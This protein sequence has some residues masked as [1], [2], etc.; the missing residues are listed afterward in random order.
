MRENTR[1]HRAIRGVRAREIPDAHQKLIDDLATGESKRA[2]EQLDPLVLAPGMM[3]VEPA[4]K[5]ATGVPQLQ[6]RPR[7]GDGGIDL[8]SVS[9]D[10][11]V[12]QEAGTVGV[13]VRGDDLGYEAM[14][15]PLKRFPLLEDSEPGEAGLIDLEHQTLEKRGVVLEREAI[16]PLVI[17]TMPWIVGGKG[18]VA[19]HGDVL[20]IALVHDQHARSDLR[21]RRWA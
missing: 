7:V 8:Q 16:L 6:N 18:T 21:R 4:G 19:G 11:A 15:G 20:L 13:T 17:G 12:I 14:I 1:V 9:D 10:A 2:L 5:G 3:R